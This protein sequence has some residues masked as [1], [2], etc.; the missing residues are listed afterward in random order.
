MRLMKAK[1]QKLYD[2]HESNLSAAR[3]AIYM[4][5]VEMEK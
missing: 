2:T 1:D 3:G 4:C 5:K